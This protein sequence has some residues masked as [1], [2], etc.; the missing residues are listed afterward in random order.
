MVVGASTTAGPLSSWPSAS[1]AVVVD[2]GVLPAASRVEE[3]PS[4]SWSGWASPSPLADLA[5]LGP[6]RQ[7]PDGLGAVGDQLQTRLGETRTLAVE[8]LVAEPEGRSNAVQSSDIEI[9]GRHRG[10]DLGE[11]HRV[12]QV[13]LATVLDVGEAQSLRGQ[14]ILQ[15]ATQL[16]EGAVELGRL[17][18]KLVGEE[19]SAVR[20]MSEAASP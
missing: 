3:H 11:L 7:H 12:P 8:L 18:G 16:T 17:G 10:G 1:V 4:P 15:L 2:V 19:S 6:D 9:T 5:E 20:T 13:G 14:P